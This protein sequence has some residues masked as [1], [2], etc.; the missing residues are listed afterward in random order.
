MW[1]RAAQVLGLLF[2]VVGL[3][4]VGCTLAM[5]HWRVAQLGGEGGSSVVVVAWFWSD[6]WK[7]CY[8]DSTSLVNCVDF[9]VLW[10][11]RSYIQA[12]R[13]LLLTGLCLGFIATVLTLFGME[14]TRVGGDQRSKDRMLAAASA[15]HVFGCGSDVAGYCLYINTVAAAFLHGKADPSKLS[16]EIGPPLYLGLGGSFII[17]L[18]CTVQYVT[19]CRVKQPKSRHAVVA[20]IREK[21]EGSIRRQK[22]RRGPSQ[23]SSMSPYKMASAVIV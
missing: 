16:Y 23:R 9:G 12:V 8:E 18:G 7:D 5:D 6:L 10:T 20:S 17:L 14:C 2:C 19:A 1:R 21:E 13:G 4:L 3:G 15:L 22:H 11:V